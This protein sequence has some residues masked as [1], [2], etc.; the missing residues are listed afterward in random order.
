MRAQRSEKYIM[1]MKYSIQGVACSLSSKLVQSTTV[2]QLPWN[3]SSQ[4]IGLLIFLKSQNPG[5]ESKQ[6]NMLDSN[7]FYWIISYFCNHDP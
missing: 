4:T 7:N 1:F 3:I 6:P 2:M 5:P